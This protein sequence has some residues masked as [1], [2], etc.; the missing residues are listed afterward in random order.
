MNTETKHTAEPW[1][2]ESDPVD[3]LDTRGGFIATTLAPSSSVGTARDYANARRIVAAV[4]AVAGMTT[5]ELESFGHG[6]LAEMGRAWL[7]DD[8]D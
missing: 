1:R 4:N 8:N 7:A 5:E 6:E 2:V 3:V